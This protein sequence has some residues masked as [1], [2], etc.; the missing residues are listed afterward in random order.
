[1]ELKSRVMSQEQQLMHL[2]NY[3]VSFTEKEKKYFWKM[4]KGFEGEC[5][6][7]ELLAKSVPNENCLVL[8]DL[9]LEHN[10]T[11]FQLDSVL[12]ST[13]TIYI[14]EIKTFEG[15]YY[16][17]NGEWFFCK[18][19]NAITNPLH[20]MQRSE[21]LLRQLLQQQGINSHLPI[22]SNLIFIHPEFTLYHSSIDSPIIFPTQLNRFMNDLGKKITVKPNQRHMQLAEKLKSMHISRPSFDNIPKYN[23]ETIKKGIA[24]ASCRSLHVHL[25]GGTKF[26]K[27]CCKT[28][29]HLEGVDVSILRAVKEYKLLFPDRKV[30]T[31]EI[32]Q[33]CGLFK[34]KKTI[35]RIMTKY[36]NKVEKNRYSYFEVK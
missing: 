23:F 15:D 12:L 9:L 25:I 8:N 21:T 1:M 5:Q 10:N 28:C 13:S 16:I 22:Q 30:T 7:D 3:R 4:K 19:N 32:L 20:Q 26:Q 14:F 34:S 24:C 35:L 2:L 29:G 17:K 11:Q 6:F 27:I 18:T 31:S 33:W 36:F